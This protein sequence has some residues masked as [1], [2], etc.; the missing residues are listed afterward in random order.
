MTK[1]LKI[2]AINIISIFILVFSDQ[3][4]ASVDSDLGNF[5]SGLGYQNNVSAPAAYQGQAAGYYTGGSL[6]LRNQVRDYQIVSVEM[7]SFSGGCSG[8]D[9]YLGAFSVISSS[10][11]T[12][13][14]K[15]I[16]SAGGAYAFDLALTTTVPQIKSVKDYI[17]KHRN[18]SNK[19][20]V[21]LAL[22]AAHYQIGHRLDKTVVRVVN[23][24]H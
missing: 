15:N 3:S 23:L 16:L 24:I 17:Q 22:I 12:A 1:I 18:R 2:A 8:I 20:V 4:Q 13:M 10:Q 7:P 9:S 5:F 14:M 6:Y 19:S 11:F 21:T